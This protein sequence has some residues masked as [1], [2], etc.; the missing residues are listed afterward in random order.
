LICS[1]E[2]FRPFATRNDFRIRACEP[3]QDRI[4]EQIIND[5]VRTPEQF[6]A[7]QREQARVA[8]PG[9]DEIN[10][11]FGFHAHNLSERW[12]RAMKEDK[13]LRVF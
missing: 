2:K 3:E 5:R 7:A 6:R 4:D 9:T 11:A 10:R 13:S 1:C 12:R 8:R